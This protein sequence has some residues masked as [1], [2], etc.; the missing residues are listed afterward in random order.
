MNTG[1]PLS[2]NP[3]HALAA[4]TRR[5]WTQ[6]YENTS[7]QDL[8]DDTQ[9]SKSSLYQQFGN[10]KA[11]FNRCL[12][13]YAAEMTEAL[14]QLLEHSPSGK[15]FVQTMLI[16]V[17]SEARPAKSCLIFNTASEFGQNDS[18][19]AQ[20]V[21]AAMHDFRSVFLKALQQDQCAGLLRAEADP[22]ALADYLITAIGGLRTMVKA[23]ASSSSL[24]TTVAI[25]MRSLD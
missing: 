21:Q 24:K 18:E 12:N 11:L 4:A 15:T 9:L 23:G 16:Q 22:Q 17:I 2:F 19:I 6:G 14:E 8:L 7:L 20:Q 10:K 5:F 25:I 3:E 1:R 13:H